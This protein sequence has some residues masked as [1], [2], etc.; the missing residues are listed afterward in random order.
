M[1]LEASIRAGDLAAAIDLLRS[2]ADANRR[3]PEGLTPLM[4][5]C[6]L[7]QPQVSASVLVGAQPIFADFSFR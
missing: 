1:T 7:G 5:A 4:I 2:G 3:G 6:G